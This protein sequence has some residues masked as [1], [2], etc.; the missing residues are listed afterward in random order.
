MNTFLRTSVLLGVF[1]VACGSSGTTTG[2]G[3]AAGSAASAGT[4]GGGGRSGA[5]G[6]SGGSNCPPECL[7]A[8]ECVRKCGDVPQNFGC[9][10]CPTGMINARSCPADAGADAADCG[11]VGAPC[12]P[13]ECGAGLT[14][15]MGVCGPDSSECARPPG[16]VGCGA[17][18]SCLSF[19]GEQ[20]GICVS[21]QHRSCLCDN[22]AAVFDCP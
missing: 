13:G 3:G 19:A 2:H 16:G 12:P 14:C 6:A 18:Q 15:V 21:E 9:C 8:N 11:L 1:A 10:P 4:A 22:A 20:Q 7:V 5:G 17:G